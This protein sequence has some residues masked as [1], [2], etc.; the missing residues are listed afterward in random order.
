MVQHPPPP[1][2]GRNMVSSADRDWTVPKKV[3]HQTVR[4]RGRAVTHPDLTTKFMIF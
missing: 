2:L 3:N 1:K 4:C